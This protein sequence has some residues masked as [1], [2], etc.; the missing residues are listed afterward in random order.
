MSQILLDAH[1]K[2]EHEND[3]RPFKCKQCVAKGFPSSGKLKRHV[4]SVHLKLRA[5]EPKFKC[6]FCGKLFFSTSARLKHERRR[7]CTNKNQPKMDKKMA[8]L[9]DSA[10]NSGLFCYSVSL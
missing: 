1:V 7:V 2:K 4:N 9:S 10:D 5:G 6:T 3:P 8:T